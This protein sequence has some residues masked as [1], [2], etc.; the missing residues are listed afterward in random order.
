MKSLGLGGPLECF[1]V[2]FGSFFMIFRFCEKNLSLAI[3]DSLEHIG[4]LDFFGVSIFYKWK[5]WLWY[6]TIISTSRVLLYFI[7]KLSLDSKELFIYA[8]CAQKIRRK[9]STS[10][11]ASLIEVSKKPFLTSE[12]DSWLLWSFTFWKSTRLVCCLLNICYAFFEYII[13]N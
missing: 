1:L 10:Q 2:K 11:K 6:R 9:N 8:W 13:H 7:P 5:K 4:T 12:I 3:W